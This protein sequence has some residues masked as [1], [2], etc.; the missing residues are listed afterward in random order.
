M[1]LGEVLEV[2]VVFIHGQRVSDTCI[3]VTWRAW[4]REIHGV[5]E[6]FHKN[7]KTGSNT[8][9]AFIIQT[10][11]VPAL[12]SSFCSLVIY[13]SLLLIMVVQSC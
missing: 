8:E 12:A 7:S 3:R 2:Y 6:L 9:T 1:N 10:N 5:S 11:I 4:I 13:R